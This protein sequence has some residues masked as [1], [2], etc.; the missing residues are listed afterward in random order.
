VR[1]DRHTSRIEN[2]K[3]KEKSA[4]HVMAGGPLHMGRFVKID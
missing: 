4:L 2:A 3:G 1:D